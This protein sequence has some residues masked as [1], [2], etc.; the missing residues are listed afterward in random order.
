MESGSVGVAEGVGAAG[1]ASGETR[2]R[3]GVF[4]VVDPWYDYLAI[5]VAPLVLAMQGWALALPDRRRG[6]AVSAAGCLAIA[7]MFAFVAFGTVVPDHDP[8]IGAGVLLIELVGSFG[9]LAAQV[10][11]A[12][13]H[14]TKTKGRRSVAS[15]VDD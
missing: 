1:E 7:A 13:L 10:A 15:P 12:T 6:I 5:P 8:N 4:G 2:D 14:L 11:R 3:L 9:L